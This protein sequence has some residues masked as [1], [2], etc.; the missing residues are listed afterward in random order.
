MYDVFLVTPCLA[1]PNLKNLEKQSSLLGHPAFAEGCLHI[2]QRSFLGLD[3][4]REFAL[5]LL[6]QLMTAGAIGSVAPSRYR[7]PLLSVEAAIP[8]AKAAVADLQTRYFPT[9]IFEP[10]TFREQEATAWIFA[11]PCPR[12]VMEGYI[13]GRLSVAIDKLDG[14][15]WNDED[16]LHEVLDPPAD[17]A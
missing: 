4:E 5:T 15:V 7:Q 16:L 14:H 9:D 11:A 13:P 3:L 1:L 6:H 17:D 2:R 12:L 10:V 8:L